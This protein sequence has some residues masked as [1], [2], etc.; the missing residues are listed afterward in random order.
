MRRSTQ[1]A[2]LA[3]GCVLVSGCSENFA[4]I[5]RTA[6]LGEGDTLIT[7]AK[8][9]TVLNLEPQQMPAA[10]LVQPKRI[11]CAEPSPDVGQAISE[12]FSAS[13]SAAVAAKGSGQADLAFALAA[14]IAELG[15]RLAS[16]QA[17][18][19]ALYRACEGYANGALSDVSYALILSSYDDL[20]ETTLFGDFVASRDSKGAAIDTSAKS[21]AE[22]KASEESSSESSQPQ[23]AE[24]EETTT[25]T[26][27]TTTG[28]APSETTVTEKK[29]TKSTAEGK[30]N[31]EASGKAEAGTTSGTAVPAHVAQALVTMHDTAMKQDNHDPNPLIAACVAAM[32]RRQ[33]VPGGT[34][35]EQTPFSRFCELTIMPGVASTMKLAAETA[36]QTERLEAEAERLRAETQLLL[37]KAKQSPS[38]PQNPG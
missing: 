29:T 35:S 3:A 4:S 9:R 15:K 6:E 1:W 19:D 7:D 2:G 25:T 34:P 31:A 23:T 30:A 21:A 10:G 24:T 38:Q 37:Q 16:V 12:S 22:G 20:L 5:Y 26:T 13:A 32:D 28:A 18:R 8:Q 11:I 17:L 27:T 14:N 33:Y 36:M